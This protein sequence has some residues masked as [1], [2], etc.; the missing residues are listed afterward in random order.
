MSK[1]WYE[2]DFFHVV[3]HQ[4]FLQIDSN[5]W[6]QDVNWMMSYVRSI[7]VLCSGGRLLR[8]AIS[9]EKPKGL[10]WFFLHFIKTLIK[11]VKNVPF[12]DRSV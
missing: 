10:S 8:R 3:T 4:N 2:V 12:L 9:Q 1:V 11:G 7:Y 6:T 5:P